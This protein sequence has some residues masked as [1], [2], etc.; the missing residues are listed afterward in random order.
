MQ[1]LIYQW[2]KTFCFYNHI[3]VT[4]IEDVFKALKK[5]N[6]N[7]HIHV[8]L[9]VIQFYVQ[10]KVMY[11]IHNYDIFKQMNSYTKRVTFV[12]KNYLRIYLIWISPVAII[13]LYI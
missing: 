10:R 1:Q 2:N 4:K 13:L 9:S 6:L 7:I 11:V 8:H 5:L 3:L 12:S